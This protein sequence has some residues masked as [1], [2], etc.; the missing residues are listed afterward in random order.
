MQTQ[1]LPSREL[2]EGP[3]LAPATA[4]PDW[5]E[6][7]RE[8]RRA[9]RN[10]LHEAGVPVWGALLIV[11]GMVALLGS[12]GLALGWLFGLAL[13]AWFVYLGVRPALAR[14]PEDAASTPIH[15]WLVGIGL[16]IGLGS[17]TSGFADPLVFPIVLILVGLGIVGEQAWNRQV[18]PQ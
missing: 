17:I 3:P 11:I 15:W 1:Q 6:L 18:P 9:R 10:H 7:R 12:F 14:A 5:R 2:P 4:P 13:G 8:E 16:L